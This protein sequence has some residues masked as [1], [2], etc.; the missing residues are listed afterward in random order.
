MKTERMILCWNGH[1]PILGELPV[2][3]VIWEKVECFMDVVRKMGTRPKP[4]EG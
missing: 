1:L 3:D 4:A 2:E